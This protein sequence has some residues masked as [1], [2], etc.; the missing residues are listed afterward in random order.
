[1]MHRY[2]SDTDNQ[3]R[4]AHALELTTR[5]GMEA[6]DRGRHLARLLPI[7]PEDI[8]D[9]TPAMRRR[10]VR[11]LAGALRAERMR[12]R[13]GHWTYDLNRHIALMQA[14]AAERRHV[15]GTT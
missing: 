8:A 13:A 12:G 4:A 10:I 11:R 1:M 5:A 15:D 7:G 3:R 9:E 14:Y 6:Y 2:Q